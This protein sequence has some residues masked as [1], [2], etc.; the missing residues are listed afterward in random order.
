MVPSKKGLFSQLKGLDSGAS[1]FSGTPGPAISVDSGA[2]HF[3][4][5]PGPA[6]DSGASH[7][8]GGR[9]YRPAFCIL[10]SVL[11]FHFGAG[12]LHFALS[13]LHSVL[14]FHFGKTPRAAGGGKR[15][16]LNAKCKSRSGP[17]CGSRPIGASHLGQ[18]GHPAQSGDP[19]HPA[20]PAAPSNP[21]PATRN[22]VGARRPLLWQELSSTPSALICVI[23]G[24]ILAGQE[25]VGQA[26]P[27]LRLSPPIESLMGR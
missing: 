5:T 18:S 12:I 15:S 9:D 20:G 16:I 21:P 4:G 3:W 7:F 22:A 23:C 1:H 25:T 2:S 6:G 26:V 27:G 10:Q 13:I 11:V 8:W 14:P 17:L 19:G 24:Q